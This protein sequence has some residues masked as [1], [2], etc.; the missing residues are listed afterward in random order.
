MSMPTEMIAG[1]HAFL[2]LAR[3]G[4]VA[5]NTLTIWRHCFACCCLLLLSISVSD[6]ELR[7]VVRITDGDTI[8]VKAGADQ[9]KTRLSGIDSPER[10]QPL[11]K[12][13]GANLAALVADKAV[14]VV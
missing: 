6:A 14:V 12:E 11:Y 3:G 4:E 13:T 7:G 9:H 5:F 2:A 8:V 1:R 10:G